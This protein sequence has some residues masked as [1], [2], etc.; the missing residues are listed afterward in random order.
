MS[1]IILY[2]PE[3]ELHEAIDHFLDEYHSTKMTRLASD[4][5]AKGLEPREIVTSVR[6]AVAICRTAG[7][8]TRRHFY[9]VYTQYEGATVK[10]CKLSPFGF[11]LVL[12]NGPEQRLITA[13]FQIE[14]LR[15]F[16]EE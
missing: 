5:L 7:I 8:D 14:L 10:D 4:L 9:P 3:Y 12:L 1:D 16:E 11:K 13:E 15:M 2:Q 6:K